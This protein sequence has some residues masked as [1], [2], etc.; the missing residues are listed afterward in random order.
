MP[1]YM[2]MYNRSA[3]VEGRDI[4]YTAHAHMYATICSTCTLIN[5]FTCILSQKVIV[6]TWQINL[7]TCRPAIF[8]KS[9][10]KSSWLVTSINFSCHSEILLYYR[11]SF[12]I[13]R[14]PLNRPMKWSTGYSLLQK[15]INYMKPLVISS[16][17]PRIIIPL[18]RFIH[19]M[20]SVASL[21]HSE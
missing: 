8:V 4:A 20:S 1:V 21:L 3:A 16:M 12:K 9:H 10:H 15:P 14:R 17:F 5:R 19:Q 2:Y 18:N 13:D 6:M 11:C 7:L